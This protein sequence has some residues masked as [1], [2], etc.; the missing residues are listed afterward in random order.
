[1]VDPPRL[2][3]KLGAKW[4]EVTKAMLMSVTTMEAYLILANLK[5]RPATA[6]EG[7]P[8]SKSK[9]A[10]VKRRRTVASFLFKGAAGVGKLFA[11][12][13]QSTV[14]GKQARSTSDFR[15][16]TSAL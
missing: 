6:V 10:L 9:M 8:R 2:H 7:S 4:V 5:L 15:K 1:M 12:D 14:D 16:R 3:Q 11:L 13:E